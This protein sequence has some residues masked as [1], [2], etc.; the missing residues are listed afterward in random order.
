MFTKKLYKKGLLTITKI[1]SIPNGSGSPAIYVE[2]NVESLTTSF[3]LGIEGE[4][5]LRINKNKLLG[6]SLVYV[7]YK[8]NGKNTLQVMGKYSSFLD[9]FYKKIIWNFLFQVGGLAFPFVIS[10]GIY[11]FLTI[12]LRNKNP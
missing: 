7:W 8:P 6:D 11:I 9:L 10:F 4:Q 3:L 1:E 2:G 12:K 5:E